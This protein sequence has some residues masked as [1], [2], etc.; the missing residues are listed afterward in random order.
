MPY[1]TQTSY[2]RSWQVWVRLITRSVTVSIPSPSLKFSD[3]FFRIFRTAVDFECIKLHLPRLPEK[4][5]N[6]LFQPKLLSSIESEITGQVIIWLS[7]PVSPSA[8][9]KLA[10]ARLL[11]LLSREFINWNVGA[12]VVSHLTTSY[13][14]RNNCWLKVKLNLPKSQLSWLYWDFWLFK[15]VKQVTTIDNRGKTMGQAAIKHITGMAE[16]TRAISTGKTCM[17]SCQGRGLAG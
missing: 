13:T 9:Q 12:L 3:F 6:C 14:R 16:G 7:V 17:L 4:G 11:G 15:E 8:L 1:H 5:I 10:N 2:S